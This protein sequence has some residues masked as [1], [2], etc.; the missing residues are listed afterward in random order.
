M[1][2][3]SILLLI[4]LSF[5]PAL[6]EVCNPEDRE[7]LLQI[8]KELGNPFSLATW[9]P[10]TDCCKNKWVGVSCATHTQKYR[11][12]HLVLSQLN[13]PKAYRIPPSIGDLPYL[14]SLVITAT[15][16][17]VGTLP[18]TIAKLT[19]LR[20]IT[21]RYT[22]ISGQIPRFLSQIKTL[23]SIE[24]TYNKL[25]G[26]LPAWL[27]SL[28]ILSTINFDGNSFSGAIPDSF[29]SFRKGFSSLSLSNNRL[30]GKIPA[31]FANLD[32]KNVDLSHNMLEGDASMLFGSRKHTERIYLQ[33]NL[34]AFDFGKVGLSK[35]LRI[36]DLTQNRIYGTLP[37]GLTLLTSLTLLDV[38]HNNLCGEIPRGG[39]LQNTDVSFYAHNKCLCGSPLP[40]C[41]R[42]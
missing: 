24:F 22:N 2:R 19:K 29:G 25:S 27:P 10:S 14:Q 33:N 42:I 4:V 12:K 38:S 5:S 7:V 15:D 32:M 3:L 41:K 11:V 1:S 6:S 18:P 28:P 16:N 30:N 40:K 35:T 21:I 9:L 8:K 20:D 23:E 37:K 36:L 26:P 31:A 34:F 39:S 17:I 13:L